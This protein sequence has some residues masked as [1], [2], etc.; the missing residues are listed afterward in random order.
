M[1]EWYQKEQNRICQN[2]IEY[3]RINRIKKIEE[4]RRVDMRGEEKVGGMIFE[5]LEDEDLELNSLR[6]EQIIEEETGRSLRKGEK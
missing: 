1:L 5:T 3:H 6:E 2:R 4:K